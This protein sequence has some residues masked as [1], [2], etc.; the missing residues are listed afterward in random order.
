MADQSQ[1][2]VAPTP[3]KG[4]TTS[5]F[6]AIA[7]TVAA[8][9]TGHVPDQYVPAVA[10]LVGVYV[11]CRTLL[12]VIHTMGYAQQIPDLPELSFRQPEQSQ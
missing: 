7:G 8:I 10:A 2:Q 3:T 4:A 9:A 12:K 11:A 6:A 5:E 1:T